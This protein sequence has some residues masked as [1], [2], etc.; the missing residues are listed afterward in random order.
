[1]D[2]NVL[3]SCCACTSWPSNSKRHQLSQDSTENTVQYYSP[4]CVWWDHWQ[5]WKKDLQSP[6]V[7]STLPEKNKVS[8][9]CLELTNIISRHRI[10]Q[11]DRQTE[12]KTDRQRDRQTQTELNL[13]SAAFPLY[14]LKWL[15]AFKFTAIALQ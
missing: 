15:Q 5:N 10:R 4:D 14:S 9:K 11:K 12:R 6:A 13:T 2:L 8:Q 1:M 3:W 7:S